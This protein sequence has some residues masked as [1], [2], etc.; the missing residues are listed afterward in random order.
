M[1]HYSNPCTCSGAPSRM[2][3]C[4]PA[5]TVCLKLFAA[6]AA[7]SYRTPCHDESADG[8]RPRRRV[9]RARRRGTTPDARRPRRNNVAG[10]RLL[11][12]EASEAGPHLTQ[13]P[14][15]V[16]VSVAPLWRIFKGFRRPCR[17]SRSLRP[18]GFVFFLKI[19]KTI[20][21]RRASKSVSLLVRPLPSCGGGRGV[22]NGNQP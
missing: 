21:H 9:L 6:C 5:H 7:R 13:G 16:S 4:A 3:A 15:D 10:V 14:I 22:A 18:A 8:K 19:Q 20:S 11:L 17:V 12:H 2:D 1:T